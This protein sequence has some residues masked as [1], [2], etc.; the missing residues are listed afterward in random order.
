MPQDLR[1]L[2]EEYK[3]RFATAPLPEEVVEAAAEKTYSA[4]RDQYH[5]GNIPPKRGDHSNDGFFSRMHDEL[6]EKWLAA[7]HPSTQE[8]EVILQ[9]KGREA[10]HDLNFRAWNK[11][12]HAQ[13]FTPMRGANLL[14]SMVREMYAK[15]QDPDFWMKRLTVLDPT[16]GSGR[17]LYPFQRAEATTL[18]VELDT[19]LVEKAKML[20]G[21][22]SVR[23]GSVLEYAP[24]LDGAG[25][26]ICVTNP[27]YGIVWSQEESEFQFEGLSQAGNIESQNAVLQIIA[28]ALSNSGLMLAIIPTSTFENSK[29]DGLRQSFYKNFDLLFRATI[30]G[31][32][33]EE[34][35]IEVK[36]DI[37]A[38]QKEQSFYYP[39]SRGKPEP[40]LMKAN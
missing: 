36:V 9:D 12:K 18:G 27:P 29:D 26:D 35:G 39:P 21:K 10:N 8:P 2:I 13:Y 11:S 32:F 23:S 28:K 3:R 4:F 24:Y 25:F 22:E 40:V 17:L 16:A 6:Y 7:A 30:D 20:L 31:M 37:V 38:A 34:Y 33:Q 15:N 14:Y 19:E 1:I 5:P